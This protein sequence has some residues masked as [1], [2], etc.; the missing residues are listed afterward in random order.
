M[1][2]GAQKAEPAYIKTRRLHEKTPGE[3]VALNA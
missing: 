3:L 1:L 2:E